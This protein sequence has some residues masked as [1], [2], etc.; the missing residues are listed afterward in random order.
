M[1]APGGASTHRCVSR[2]LYRVLIT[3]VTVVDHKDL[4][5]IKNPQFYE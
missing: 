1:S 2:R 4:W 3:G 5:A